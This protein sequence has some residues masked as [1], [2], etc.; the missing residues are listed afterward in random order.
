MELIKEQPIEVG[1][2]RP[3]EN[4][5]FLAFA[6]VFFNFGSCKF[7][8]E[9]ELLKSQLEPLIEFFSCH[10][11]QFM[12]TQ[13][14]IQIVRTIWG[15]S[16]LDFLQYKDLLNRVIALFNENLLKSLNL[17]DCQTLIETLSLSKYKSSDYDPNFLDLL[18]QHIISLLTSPQNHHVQ[19]SM[20]LSFF[21]GYKVLRYQHSNIYEILTETLLKRLDTADEMLT[22]Y[23]INRLALSNELECMMRLHKEVLARG[24]HLTMQQP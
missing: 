18:T 9:N 5:Q 19:N 10:L 23:A 21:K 8:Q 16:R 2:G 11:E 22:F 12:Q 20:L 3:A 14:K 1:G 17:K 24:L 15:I 6:D 4:R 7:I 13:N